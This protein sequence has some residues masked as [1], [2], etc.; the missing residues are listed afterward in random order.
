[1]KNGNL[2]SKDVRLAQYK[3]SAE[4][5]SA[6]ENSYKGLRIHALPGL[7]AHV[8]DILSTCVPAP[9]SILELGAGSGALSLRMADM[10]YNVT[11]I[12]AVVDNFRARDRARFFQVDLDSDFSEYFSEMFDVVVA[13]EIIE[14]LENPMHVF[15]EVSRVIK[16]GGTFLITTPNVHNPVSVAMFC[17]FGHHLWFNQRDRNFHGH[18]RSL[19]SEELSSCATEA[20]FGMGGLGSFGDPFLHVTNWWKLRLLANFIDRFSALP[21][22]LRGEILT[23]RFIKSF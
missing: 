21:K 7:H 2:V 23:A 16:P 5:D 22:S 11:A 14:H 12:D 10:C 19:T 13:V 17:R 9:A 20:G 4:L 3:A 15:R 18:I 1:M 6:G 8:G